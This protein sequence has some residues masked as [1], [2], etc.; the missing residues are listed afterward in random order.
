[1]DIRQGRV[2]LLL[3][4]GRCH[5]DEGIDMRVFPDMLDH[6]DAVHYRHLDI[7]NHKGYLVF[8]K[9][10]QIVPVQKS[11]NRNRVTTPVLP[12]P[13][14]NMTIHRAAR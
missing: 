6:L 4:V 5:D 9:Q 1:M 14:P 8:F 12:T 10:L 3:P 13:S 2:K 11:T 7:G